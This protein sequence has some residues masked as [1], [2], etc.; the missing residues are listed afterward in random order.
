[1]ACRPVLR[2]EG[3]PQPT[4]TRGRRPSRPISLL[5]RARGCRQRGT[6]L[7]YVFQ[8]TCV[9]DSAMSTTR[10]IVSFKKDSRGFVSRDCPTCKQRFKVQLSDDGK[11]LRHCPFCGHSGSDCWMLSEHQKYAQ[12]V[13]A[14]V[15]LNPAIDKIDKAFR[16]MAKGSGGMVKVTGSV[17]R[18]KVLPQPR[19]PEDDDFVET[20]LAC[21]SEKIRHAASHRVAH[22]AICG[23][24]NPSQ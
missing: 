3:C 23:A 9:Y 1:M 13:A 20:A 8:G 15:V 21:C 22:C 7:R 11:P 5:Y 10:V 17:S 2:D 18:P 16:N 24:A 4:T 19:E 14:S 6:A 12:S